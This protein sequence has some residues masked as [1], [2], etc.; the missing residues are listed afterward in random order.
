M[1]LNSDELRVLRRDNPQALFRHLTQIRQRFLFGAED[2]RDDEEWGGECRVM[3][4]RNIVLHFVRGYTEHMSSRAE[5]PQFCVMA[6][7]DRPDTVEETRTAVDAE[8][9]VKG[10][11]FYVDYDD[12]EVLIREAVEIAERCL[13]FG[14]HARDVVGFVVRGCDE[15]KGACC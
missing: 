12:Y 11:L 3:L 5:L 4:N 1:G 14:E 13:D 8:L 10:A 15:A 2:H 7:D 9:E 6:T